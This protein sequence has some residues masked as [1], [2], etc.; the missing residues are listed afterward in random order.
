MKNLKK[1]NLFVV[2][3]AKS[4]TTALYRFLNL[5]PEI[6]LSQL[7]N[8]IIFQKILDFPTFL[9]IIER[10]TILTSKNIL[11]KKS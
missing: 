4:G 9:I 8:L 6:F 7:K 1:V 10:G 11:Q 3:A 2:G 5:H